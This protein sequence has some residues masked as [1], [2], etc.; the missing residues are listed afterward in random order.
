MLMGEQLSEQVYEADHIKNVLS[1]IQDGFPK[2]IST[3][4]NATTLFDAA[5]K[6]HSKEMEAYQKYMDIETLDEFE[7]DPNAF[8][9]ET[10]ANCPIIRRCLMSHEEIMN[11]Y[12]RSFSSVSGRDLLY[13]VYN[14]AI[15]GEQ[16]VEDFDSKSHEASESCENLRLGDLTGEERT[17][18]GVVGYGIQST[19]LYS[20]YPYAFAHRSQNAVWALYFLS[21]RLDFG[22]GEAGSEFLMVRPQ[23]GTCEQNYLYP[24]ELFGYYSLQIYLMLKKAD[25]SFKKLF[26]NEYRYI[27]LDAFFDHVANT[28]K[29]DINALKWTSED[30]D[31]H[32]Y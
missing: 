30:V 23:Y 7:A 3:F 8:K 15:F 27:Y 31:N 5:I 17:C 2:Y 19:L 18:I 16:Y 4:Q 24:P 32:W 1:A 13:T 14:I 12:K 25:P 20:L 21:G 22:L 26:K 28:H 6:L 9:K 10:K 29:A 11:G